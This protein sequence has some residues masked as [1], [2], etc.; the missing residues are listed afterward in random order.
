MGDQVKVICNNLSNVCHLVT[1]HLPSFQVMT[2]VT[3]EITFLVVPTPIHFVI[4]LCSYIHVLV[5]PKTAIHSE[6]E[7]FSDLFFRQDSYDLL[8]V[9]L[10]N[11]I[12]G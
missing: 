10:Y 8:I 6:L 7:P 12:T 4:V 5:T 11:L 3:H 1:G 2:K 9:L